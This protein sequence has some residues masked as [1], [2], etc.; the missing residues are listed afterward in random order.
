MTACDLLS[1]R[2]FSR[3]RNS[4]SSLTPGQVLTTQKIDF[5]SRPHFRP[6]GAVA[7]FVSWRAS[8][9]SGEINWICGTSPDRFEIKAIHLP[10]YDHAGPEFLP[11][12][13]VS[14]FCVLPSVDR[15]HRLD[16]LASA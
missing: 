8:P 13:F 12:K 16:V 3:L 7:R 4:P 15:S 11:L 6:A 9:P 10:S 14:C 1:L 5:P 2:S